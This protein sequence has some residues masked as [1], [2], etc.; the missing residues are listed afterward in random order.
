MCWTSVG[1]IS[2]RF[3]L[4]LRAR[5]GVRH[6]S[7]SSSLSTV[8][9][10]SCPTSSLSVDPSSTPRPSHRPHGNLPR[11]RRL[12][13][14]TLKRPR[15]MQTHLYVW[16]VTSLRTT[17]CST[18]HLG[19]GPELSWPIRS[20]VNIPTF[21]CWRGKGGER[22]CR[23]RLATET[24]VEHELERIAWNV[25]LLRFAHVAGNGDPHVGR[26]HRRA[27]PLRREYDHAVRKLC[28]I[29]G[30]FI[31]GSRQYRGQYSLV[32]A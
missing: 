14:K 1:R 12:F 19:D 7:T 5:G 15:E 28:P 17:T 11:E 29:K 16:P 26:R 32:V 18:I 23:N 2:G 4:G 21:L 30:A 6:V 22:R 27:V 24:H 25:D 31:Q 3:I 10:I 9:G 13:Q 20:V 8:R